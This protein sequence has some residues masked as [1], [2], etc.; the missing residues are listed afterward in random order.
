MGIFMD[1]KETKLT[2]GRSYR[3]KKSNDTVLGLL[4]IIALIGTVYLWV[5]N[6]YFHLDHFPPRIM[7][8]GGFVL[9]GIALWTSRLVR[10]NCRLEISNGLLTVEGGL[11]KR[12]KSIRCTDIAMVKYNRARLFPLS[13][14]RADG[15]ERIE[16]ITSRGC[17]FFKCS[18]VSQQ[19]E[20]RRFLNDLV[21]EI[22]AETQYNKEWKYDYIN[23]LFRDK[24]VVFLNTGNKR[25][26]RSAKWA[27][28][29]FVLFLLLIVPKY[30]D[31]LENYVRERR[32]TIEED[33]VYFQKTKIEKADAK[34]F[35]IL[36]LY[37]VAKD[38]A[39]VFYCG[40]IVENADVPTFKQVGHW[41][42]FIDKNH[43]YG[44]GPRMFP[45]SKELMIM[46]NMNVDVPTFE[47]V[48][49]MFKDKNYLYYKLYK[50][51]YIERIE[52]PVDFDLASFKYQARENEYIENNRVYWLD[53][54]GNLMLKRV[55][56]S[57]E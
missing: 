21:S 38:S 54:D 31:F 16:I 26:K 48:G 37:T 40:E 23:P 13:T 19:Q 36:D 28:L 8:A 41:H 4:L 29:A 18:S 44:R 14:R 34:T 12:T 7:L 27:L 32:Y 55:I 2:E 52:M 3:L 5:N 56:D 51:P 11:L 35:V 30:V 49:E 46:D 42:L 45:P 6:A 22:H 47:A 25:Q 1:K 43:L 10:Y 39:H 33:G 57:K 50:Y 24:N 17:Y 9:I 20:M 15:N 53:R